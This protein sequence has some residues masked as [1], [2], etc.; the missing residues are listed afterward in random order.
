MRE[1]SYARS[2]E[3]DLGVDI[4]VSLSM[5]V[6]MRPCHGGGHEPTPEAPIEYENSYSVLPL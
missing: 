6:L 3:Y 2:F 4:H 5:S 1:A